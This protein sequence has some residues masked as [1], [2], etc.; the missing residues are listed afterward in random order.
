MRCF[1]TDRDGYDR[2]AAEIRKRAT[3]LDDLLA[4]KR[5]QTVRE[6]LESVRKDGDRAVA[7]WEA[8]FGWKGCR[9]NRLRVPERWRRQARRQVPDATVRALSQ[10][11]ERLEFFHQ[12]QKRESWI[13]EKDGCRI[14][15]RFRPIKRVGVYVPGGQALY[16]STVLHACVP[17]R[18]A[19]VEQ[20]YMVTPP[21]ESGEV[22]PVLLLA[23]EMAGVTEIFRVGGAHA[24]AALAFGTQ[25]VPQVDK[26]VGPG[27]P[28]PVTAKRL[29]YGMVG[30]DLLPGPSEVAVIADEGTPAEWVAAELLAQAEHGSDSIA[31]LFTPSGPLLKQVAAWLQRSA[32]E[33]LLHAE[34]PG[35][36]TLVKTRNLDE[37][38]RLVNEGAYEHVAVMTRD[39]D[40]LRD[41]IYYAGALFL[42][43]Y[44]SVVFGDYLAGPSHI[45]PTGRTARF[46]SGLSVHDFLIR[47]SLV[48]MGPERVTDLGRHAH[49]LAS[50]EGFQGHAKAVMLRFQ[51]NNAKKKATAP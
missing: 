4:Q 3:D 44:S 48:S 22:A 34:P 50:F 51:R 47:T 14:G 26:I 29:L 38:V 13:V 24:I 19:G 31:H 43:D 20:I 41:A 39:P 16:P 35:G 21:N 8:Q 15:E 27:G 1:F 9:P 30:I 18:V 40:S 42:G 11:A 2:V 10:A 46:S 5:E 23:A 32:P 7:F 28:Y 6:I 17:A 45:L 49:V 36:F 25:T 37:A 12:Q 33:N